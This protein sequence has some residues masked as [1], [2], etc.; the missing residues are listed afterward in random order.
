M[1]TSSDLFLQVAK[2]CA[3]D[4]KAVSYVESLEAKREQHRNFLADAHFDSLNSEP[5][6][7][8]PNQFTGD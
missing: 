2:L 4:A 8:T 1:I 3:P 5:V 6:K 7:M